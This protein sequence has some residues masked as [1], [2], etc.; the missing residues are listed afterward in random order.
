[1]SEPLFDEAGP[2]P[3]KTPPL[4]VE[5]LPDMWGR[6]LEAEDWDDLARFNTRNESLPPSYRDEDVSQYKEINYDGY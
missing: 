3:R 5:D 2:V 6:F 1:M 4:Y